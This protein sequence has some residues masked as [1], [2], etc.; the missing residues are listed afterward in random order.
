MLQQ[1]AQWIM[2]TFTEDTLHSVKQNRKEVEKQT[3]S[4]DEWRVFC[5][6]VNRKKNLKISLERHL[7][8]T[9]YN[10]H[11]DLLIGVLFT[12]KVATKSPLPL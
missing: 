3:F 8:I 6:P 7:I 1:Q 5:P 2:I 9:Q 4:W 10:S 12:K 11:K